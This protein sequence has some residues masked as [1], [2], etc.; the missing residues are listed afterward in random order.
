[1]NILKSVTARIIVSWFMMW[2]CIMLPVELA[3]ALSF[4]SAPSATAVSHDSA[5]IQWISDLPSKGAVF[6]G[7]E[8]PGESVSE[9][10]NSLI[11]RLQLTGL[12]PDTT[13]YYY[14][15]LI[16]GNDTARNPAGVET[17]TFKTAPPPD[18]APPHAPIELKTAL[19]SAHAI[20]IEWGKDTLDTD[21]D[22]YN[23][24]VGGEFKMNTK[25]RSFMMSDLTAETSYQFDVSAVDTSSNEGPKASLT[26][27]TVSEHLHPVMIGKITVEVL[28]TDVALD[29]DTDYPTNAAVLYGISNDSLSSS[30]VLSDFNYS[31]A[32]NITGLESNT[33]YYFMVKACDEYNNC[34]NSTIQNFTTGILVEMFFD[35]TE[36]KI[37]MSAT[38]EQYYYHNSYELDIKGNAAPYSDIN[39]FINGQKIRFKRLHAESNFQFNAVNLN[40]KLEENVMR[41]TATGKKGEVLSVERKIIVD[42]MPPELI[43]ITI[44]GFTSES[45]ITIEGNI[46]DQTE[47]TVNLYIMKQTFA[48]HMKADNY[49]DF[50]DFYKQ[51]GPQT[52]ETYEVKNIADSINAS[53]SGAGT[54]NGTS[55]RDMVTAILSWI[56]SNLGSTNCGDKVPDPRLR[57]AKDIL[58]SKCA[59]D[60][61]DIAV[62]FVTLARAKGIAAKYVETVTNEWADCISSFGP[63]SKSCTTIQSHAF[64]EV[65][66]DDEQEWFPVD[67]AGYAFAEKDVDGH[68]KGV[69]EYPDST[70]LTLGY[71]RDSWAIDMDESE[72]IRTK[73]F[74]ALQQGY[75]ADLVKV[76][77]DSERIYKNGEFSVSI[78]PLEE[79]KSN[80]VQIDFVDQAGNVQSY[81]KVI[82][83]DTTPPRILAPTTLEP[84]TPSYVYEINIVG[85]VDDVSTVYVFVNE[86]NTENLANA[87]TSVRTDE[88]GTFEIPVTLSLVGGFGAVSENATRAQAGAAVGLGVPSHV[89][90]VAVDDAGQHS[91]PVEGDITYGQCSE[92]SYWKV[93]ISDPS[94]SR[95]N[96]RELLEGLAA[97][98]F[99]FNLSWQG[100]GDAQYAMVT[101]VNIR[102]APIGS[103]YEETQYDKS[104]DYITI[105]SVL[106]P[107]RTG[108]GRGV[109]IANFKPVVTDGNTTYQMEKN[110]SDRGKNGKC[111]VPGIGCFKFLLV[112]EI[113]FANVQ[114]SQMGPY[115]YPSQAN[116]PSSYSTQYSGYGGAYGNSYGGSIGMPAAT[117]QKHCFPVEIIID[118]RMDPSMIPDD[119]LK[120][121]INFL[122]NTI[123]IIE[124]FLGPL[125]EITKYVL[126]GCLV[127]WLVVFVMNIKKQFSCKWGSAL[128]KPSVKSILETVTGRS[129]FAA[130]AEQG[131][132]EV[133]YPGDN[134][135]DIK[136]AC[137]ACSSSTGSYWKT[138]WMQRFLCDRVI[139]PSVPSFQYYITSKGGGRSRI[140]MA[141][142]LK[143]AN[144]YSVSD[145][146]KFITPEQ[147]NQ[148]EGPA[149]GETGPNIPNQLNL[150]HDCQLVEQR[151]AAQIKNLWEAYDT[152]K[153]SLDDDC[154]SPHP[155]QAQCCAASY[156]ADWKWGA[157]FINPL[158]QSMCLANP[159]DSECSLGTRVVN[160]IVGMCEPDNKQTR[161]Q[162]A[163][164]LRYRPDF[165]DEMGIEPQGNV[166]YLIEYQEDGTTLSR[167]CRG[168]IKAQYNLRPGEVTNNRDFV[169]VV[170]DQGFTCISENLAD[171]FDQAN[172]AD[173]DTNKPA[174]NRSYEIFAQDIKSAALGY[175][176]SS[177]V[178]IKKKYAAA[179]GRNYAY[180]GG[181]YTGYSSGYGGGYGGGAGTSYYTQSQSQ[182]QYGTSTSGNTPYSTYTGLSGGAIIDVTGEAISDITGM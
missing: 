95:L 151:G 128:S 110:I 145:L 83:Y 92:G 94:P 3:D 178:I 148:G 56:Q 10:N 75:S 163:E 144:Q 80:N 180:S 169:G 31:R 61:S 164:N 39:V 88:N 19:V 115:S 181:S 30:A 18:T 9:D 104:E 167:V 41:I 27:A 15:T 93:T 25:A 13:Y 54:T 47:I 155:Y 62:A 147:V 66:L 105:S 114:P 36:P 158:K 157:V 16:Y 109:V 20:T 24:Y 65:Y 91:E 139:C 35:I 120:A 89:V 45:E 53:S 161:I 179:T 170:G 98:G 171:A 76:F 78:G 68:F 146:G 182:S 137:E 134:E 152:N 141:L 119:F 40:T 33:T 28:G 74:E 175:P 166:V 127:M 82:I 159:S 173:P 72:A 149:R 38:D 87:Q 100:G 5:T 107:N 126:I 85:K 106:A 32:I 140:G 57:P 4:T 101:G 112:M 67:P 121:T 59:V 86:G 70:M 29:W 130:A 43:N 129:D 96:T 116:Y 102:S 138:R 135:E 174:D 71:G 63:D 177:G 113:S 73:L 143:T 21:I 172:P 48:F 124:V 176:G 2:L 79:G 108:G 154:R 17:R 60:N 162:T 165:I 55:E 168:Y 49:S 133:R 77:V 81:S 51:Q 44:P 131:L 23:V 90:L 153:Q 69:S 42:R 123:Y 12:I 6:Y 1:M 118:E 142:N 22:S 50:P 156:M 26:A 136:G 34:A 103:A 11:H 160:G 64:S 7:N 125:T 117:L 46:T 132:C 111:T 99:G 14:A 52:R 37:N 97:F 122:N 84:Y 150:E 58:T 8:T